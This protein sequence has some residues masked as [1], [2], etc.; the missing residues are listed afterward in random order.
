MFSL[1]IPRAFTRRLID[2]YGFKKNATDPSRNGGVR[3]PS[4][5][6]GVALVNGLKHPDHLR[7]ARVCGAVLL[8]NFG[9]EFRK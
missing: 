4:M 7:I 6:S 2:A 3:M 9:C 1:P 5:T 8:L